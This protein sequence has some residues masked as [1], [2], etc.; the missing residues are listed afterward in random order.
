M[1]KMADL[2]QFWSNLQKNMDKHSI[3]MNADG[4][5]DCKIWIG[6]KDKYGY[7]RKKIKW[8]NGLQTI[9]STHRLAYMLD[10]RLLREDVPRLAPD[11]SSLDVSHTCNNKCCVNP[12]HLVLEKHETNMSRI[13]C[14]GHSIYVCR[15][16][17]PCLLPARLQKGRV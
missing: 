14:F 1:Y 16:E 11:G 5:I 7:G 6:S 13:H 17:P 12:R 2:N 15:H 3:I 4:E 9:E 10:Q 8:P